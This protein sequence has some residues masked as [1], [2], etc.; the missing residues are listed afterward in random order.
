MEF[1]TELSAGGYSL[2]GYIIPF[3]IV[4]TIVVFFHEL[5]HYAVA[6]WNDV[7]IEAFAVG[8]GPELF[9]IND[10][11]G[12]RWKLC[13]IPLGGYVK[14]AGDANAASVPDHEK[15][16][17]M[18]EE[19][20]A[21]SFEHKTVWQRAAV[22]VAGP[23]ANF[24]L[25][26]VIFA[27]SFFFIGIYEREPVVSEVIAESAAFEA[28]IEAGD[29]IRAID[30]TEIRSFSDIPRIA[31]PN[32]GIELIFTV[33][34]AG[35]LID[36]PVTPKLTEREDNFGNIHKTGLIGIATRIEDAE[37][38]HRTF[39]VGEALT[40]AVGE[41][42]FIIK[43]TMQ[44]LGAIIVGRESADQLSGP[45]GIAK[46]SG[47]VA[48]LGWAALINLAAILSVSI[49]LLNLFP[50][51]MLDGGHLVF[52]A[53]EAV[54]GKPLSPRAQEIGFRFGF[55]L[56]IGLMLFA[57]RNDVVNMFMR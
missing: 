22:V 7:D 26:V 50:V 49:G 16:A 40:K 10:R 1:L 14:F 33:E 29:I 48:T 23:V 8:F 18:N 34:R 27:G 37:P 38:K 4:L 25:A 30:G 13:V 47:D 11:N 44:Y 2:F 53:Y 46:L 42:F 24:I 52:Y 19:E 9:G 31:G 56:L 12:T 20:K 15:L 3:L 5:G 43:R 54:F 36:L 45:I 41:T 32:H 21:G 39:G 28:G 57:T 17:N 6:R 51:P 55:V 35:R